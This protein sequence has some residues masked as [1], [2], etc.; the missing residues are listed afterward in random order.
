MASRA[1]LLLGLLVLGGSPLG[2][3]P[4]RLTIQS[5][6]DGGPW[7]S[8]DALSPLAGRSV[9]LRVDAPDGAKIRWFQILPDLDTMYNNANFPWDPDPYKWKG[10]AKIH[11][12]RE[13][14][15]RF[16]GQRE[17]ELFAGKR[18]ERATWTRVYQS[19]TV[20]S[21][22]FHADVGS[23]WFQAEV[24]VQGTR[25]SSPGLKDSDQYGLSP[26]VLRVSVRDGEGYLGYLTS[27]FNVP[28]LFGSVPRQNNLYLGADCADV[29]VAAQGKWSGRE[30]KRDYNV[31][32]LVKELPPVAEFEMKDGRPD[33]AVAWKTAIKPGDWIAVRYAGQRMYQHIGALYRDADGDGVLGPEDIVLHAGPMPLAFDRLAE[34]GF[35][36]HVVI[37]RPPTQ[38]AWAE[39]HAAKPQ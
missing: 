33:R 29:L 25:M 16:S 10:F 4:R 24:E 30:T 36:G 28:A 6:V 38:K 7:Q 11:Y 8:V 37:L 3:A 35:D 18:G 12:D 26:K 15:D 32:A 20:R 23:F 27:F 31:A 17:I 13:E 22:Y 1:A 19:K 2:A 21:K 5:S 9:R 39:R 14:L 34:K